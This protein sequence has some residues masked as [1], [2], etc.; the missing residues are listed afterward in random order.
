MFLL[1]LCVIVFFFLKQIL[2]IDPLL[3]IYNMSKLA[4][5][6]SHELVSMSGFNAKNNQFLDLDPLVNNFSDET[7]DF[8]DKKLLESKNIEKKTKYFEE[9][10]GGLMDDQFG[11]VMHNPI[12]T[13]KDDVMKQ[14][15]RK[16]KPSN[17]FDTDNNHACQQ[18]SIQ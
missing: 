4:D 15:N 11:F 1:I 17:R 9:L 3:S 10:K 6:T 7:L 13:S 14:I 2:R 5:K 18:C 16:N 8:P 12:L